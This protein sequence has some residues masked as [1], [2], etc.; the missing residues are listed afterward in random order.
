MENLST[1]LDFDNDSSLKIFAGDFFPVEI[2]SMKDNYLLKI[3]SELDFDAFIPGD[4]DLSRYDMMENAMIPLALC[5]LLSEFGSGMNESIRLIKSGKQLVIIGLWSEETY[6][7]LPEALRKQWIYRDWKEA[8]G[9]QLTEVQKDDI[10]ILATHGP[11]SFADSVLTSFREVDLVICANGGGNNLKPAQAGYLLNMDNRSGAAGVVEI[12]CGT[13]S[14][15][16][17][18][19]LGIENF[20]ALPI[21]QNSPLPAPKVKTIVDE[22]YRKWYDS[23]VEKRKNYPSPDK[24]FLGNKYCG[25]CHQ[26]EYADWN[27]T[28]HARAFDKVRN[29]ENRCI[30]CHTT[31]FGYPTGFWDYQTTPKFAGVGCE[32]CHNV[33]KIPKIAGKHFVEPVQGENCKCHIPPHDNNFDYEK[34]LLQIKHQ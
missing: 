29:R 1:I 27:N 31:G 3:A 11:E 18:S 30:P 7:L 10:V 15:S 9:G 13:Q 4:K 23:I 16:R 6:R 21:L 19:S 33:P 14:I 22:Y 12:S 2:D 34:K 20:A 5:N 28:A 32:E 17:L 26:S 25:N 8:M 24:V